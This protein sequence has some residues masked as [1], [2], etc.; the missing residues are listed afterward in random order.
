MSRNRPAS[1][2]PTEPSPVPLYVVGIVCFTLG[3]AIMYFIMRDS[4]AA[5]PAATTAT[6]ASSPSAAAVPDVSTLPPAEAATTLGNWNYDQQN[7][8]HAIEHYEQA[9][10]LGAD[11]PN[12]RTDLGNCYR[13][14]GE[15]NK[16][17]E[18]YQIARRQNPQHENSLLN[19]AGIFQETPADQEKAVAAWREYLTRFPI[20]S[21]VTRARNFLSDAESA[22]KKANVN[23]ALK[24]LINEDVAK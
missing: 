3:A 22:A 1:K 18:Q 15:R 9:T 2:R 13:F 5:R 23:A 8:A 7:W 11:N 6:G 19:L 4:G 14:L 17:I 12:I 20:G 16:A 10:K 21:G 24:G